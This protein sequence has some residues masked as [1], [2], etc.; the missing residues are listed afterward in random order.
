MSFLTFFQGPEGENSSKRLIGISAG[1]LFEILAC[2]GALV[3]LWQSKDDKF[4][5]LVELIGYFSSYHLTTGLADH[6]LKRRG[7]KHGL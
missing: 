1:L 5:D 2:I 6:F 7:K 3:F 4:L